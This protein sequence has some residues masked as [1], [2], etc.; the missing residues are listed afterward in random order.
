MN[1][2]PDRHEERLSGPF[3]L[4][5]VVMPDVGYNCAKPVENTEREQL[6]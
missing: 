1:G 3:G 4:G 5:L 6:P 2:K